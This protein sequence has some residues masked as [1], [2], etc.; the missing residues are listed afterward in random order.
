M[1]ITV[2]LLVVFPGPTKAASPKKLGTF[3]YWHTYVLYEGKDPVCYMSLTADPPHKKGKENQRGN[4]VLM[5]THRPAESSFDVVSYKAGAQ[6]KPST[7]V[8]VRA[9]GKKFHLFTKNDTAWARDSA[10]DQALTLALRKDFNAVVTGQLAS[11]GKIAD[12]VNLKGSNAAYKQISK[13][14]AAP[15]MSLP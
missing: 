14:C 3:G 12:N 9:D 5:I 6:F 8:V 7:D 11:K 2:S 4:V 1:I 15:V 13:A 10:T